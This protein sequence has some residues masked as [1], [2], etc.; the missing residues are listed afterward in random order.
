M[1]WLEMAKQVLIE[2]SWIGRISWHNELMS[3][4]IVTFYPCYVEIWQLYEGIACFTKNVLLK[5]YQDWFHHLKKSTDSS[6]KSLDFALYY[7]SH[8]NV[9]ISFL[10][11]KNL[12]SKSKKNSKIQFWYFLIISYIY[13]CINPI[14]VYIIF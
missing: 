1:C 3:S 6:S 11:F 10:K 4:Y 2:S 14:C 12:S 7:I 13:I 9:W 8:S 5:M